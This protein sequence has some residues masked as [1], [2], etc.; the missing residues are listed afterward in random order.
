MT[1]SEIVFC[2]SVHLAHSFAI[3]SGNAPIKHTYKSNMYYFKKPITFEIS[4][5][6]GILLKAD[7]IFKLEKNT[8]HSLFCEV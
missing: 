2:L 5:L 6:V 3:D 4:S 8:L 1:F 7:S